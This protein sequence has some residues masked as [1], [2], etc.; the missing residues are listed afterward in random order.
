MKRIAAPWIVSTGAIMEHLKSFRNGAMRCNPRSLVGRNI[1]PVQPKSSITFR[2][3]QR[4]VM[5]PAGVRSSRFVN[6]APES[7]NV[8]LGHKQKAR[9]PAKVLRAQLL[10][11]LLDDGRLIYDSVAQL[12]RNM[13]EAM[14]PAMDGKAT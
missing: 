4:P 7:S 11:Q 3:S 9:H 2:L 14:M 5:R 6:P 13:A 1:P 10:P 8:F 12:G